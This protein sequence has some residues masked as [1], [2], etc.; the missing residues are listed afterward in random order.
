MNAHC[1]RP[2]LFAGFLIRSLAFLCLLASPADAGPIRWDKSPSIPDIVVLN[3]NGENVRFYSDL[4]KGKTVVIDFIFTSCTTTCPTLTTVLRNAQETLSGNTAQETQFISISVD[5]LND[6]PEKLKQYAARFEAG[7]GWTF[8]TGAKTDIDKLLKSLGA[9]NGKKENHQPLILI[10]NDNA[11]IWT[12]SYGIPSPSSIVRIV[13]ATMS[14]SSSKIDGQA[15]AVATQ[16]HYVA[17]H[18][19]AVTPGLTAID[20]TDAAKYFTNLPLLTQYG[21]R[22]KF[23]DDLIQ[24]KIVLINTMF[25]HCTMICSPMTQNL[26]KV[27]EYLGADWANNVHII[28]ITVDPETDSP[29]VLKKFAAGFNS[30]PKWTFVTG[31]REN[32]DWVL[33]KLGAYTE[34]ADEHYS[35]L[36]VGNETTGEWMK[37]FALAKPED[38]VAAVKEVAGSS[39]N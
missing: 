18:N 36:I 16:A 21:T 24:G 5:P 28:S 35:L 2:S 29:D 31:K 38:I 9:T 27:Q 23:Y 39:G 7:A 14:K 30:G 12:R 8:V 25:T 26:A 1:S 6:Q 15:A 11:G 33:Y 22:V 32:I 3:Q 17:N 37:I 34:R 20:V 10:G 13:N 19:A 4:I